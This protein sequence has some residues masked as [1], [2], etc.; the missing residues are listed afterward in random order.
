MK[1]DKKIG[2]LLW[3]GVSYRIICNTCVR[4]GYTRNRLG[5][6]VWPIRDG[7]LGEFRQDCDYCATQINPRASSS[8][9][10]LLPYEYRRN[11]REPSR[12]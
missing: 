3:N 7:H 2:T 9:P 5:A 4:R 8:L 12:I 6:E 1:L 10:E 11:V